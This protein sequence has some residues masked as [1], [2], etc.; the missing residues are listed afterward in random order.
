MDG[1]EAGAAAS[2]H[3][4]ATKHGWR[5]LV[6]VVPVVQ[7]E[8]VALAEKKADEPTHPPIFSPFTVLCR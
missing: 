6:L 7:Y 3:Y 4:Y 8:R 2:M 1:D 5:L